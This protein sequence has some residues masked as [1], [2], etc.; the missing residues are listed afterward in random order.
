MQY[1]LEFFTLLIRILNMSLLEP[2]KTLTK[3]WKERHNES[4]KKKGGMGRWNKK[5]ADF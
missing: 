4:S 3:E 2:K 1:W 5:D